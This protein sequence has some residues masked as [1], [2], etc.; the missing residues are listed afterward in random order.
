MLR[1]SKQQDSK[2]TKNQ[3]H[4]VIFF[5]A[6][7]FS[8]S[9]LAQQVRGNMLFIQQTKASQPNK[10]ITSV[11]ATAPT[12]LNTPSLRK[13]NKGKD[14]NVAIVPTGNLSVWGGPSSQS[15]QQTPTT[16]PEVKPIE[17]SQSTVPQAVRSTSAPWA[18]LSDNSVRQ[19]TT[20]KNWA[21]EES[22]DEP[23]TTQTRPR[24]VPTSQLIEDSQ[25]ELIRT[26][27]IDMLGCRHVGSSL[28]KIVLNTTPRRCL[29]LSSYVLMQRQ[30]NFDKLYCSPLRKTTAKDWIKTTCIR[31][32]LV[33]IIAHS[34]KLT[35]FPLI[36]VV[37][38]NNVTSVAG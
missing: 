22:D 11:A 19:S 21:D 23:D 28:L 37:N 20:K 9:V 3:I 35:Q 16:A 24:L 7:M 17:S 15:N 8:Y 13:E 12:P 25:S 33:E 18:K 4:E 10:T 29:R 2:V 32:D 26:Y 34:G 31:V 27:R 38:V 5:H 14:V 1:Q 30:S 36:L 6:V